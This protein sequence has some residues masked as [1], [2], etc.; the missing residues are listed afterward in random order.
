[1]LNLIYLT[2]TSDSTL[3]Q[4]KRAGFDGYIAYNPYRAEISFGT[5]FEYYD[6][7]TADIE[8]HQDRYFEFRE[9]TKGKNRLV[10]YAS[11]IERAQQMAVWH[12]D[13]SYMAMFRYP[14][15]NRGWWS[16]FWQLY[17]TLPQKIKAFKNEIPD[18][19]K[20]VGVLQAFGGEQDYVIPTK[21]QLDIM[22]R[23]WTSVMGD[24]LVGFAYFIW[25]N[26]DTE[27]SGWDTLKSYPYLWPK[28]IG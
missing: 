2:E 1:M 4:I 28:Y 14:I 3:D 26:T 8:G 11:N 16:N 17:V 12:T 13:Y 9:R 5:K 27:G 21:R 6:E 25:E 10:A 23:T 19:A 18:D 15:Q 22:R 7:P 24:R 20:V